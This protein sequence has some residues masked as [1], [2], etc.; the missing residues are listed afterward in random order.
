MVFE[1]RLISKVA[2][3]DRC[4]RYGG[5]RRGC[6]ATDAKPRTYRS[7]I[8]KGQELSSSCPSRRIFENAETCPTLARVSILSLIHIP[9]TCGAAAR[10]TRRYIYYRYQ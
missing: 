10:Y 6:Q 5:T 4:Q 1:D 2:H 3:Y 8:S 7:N 9:C